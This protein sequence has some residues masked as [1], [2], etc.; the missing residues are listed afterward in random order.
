MTT[1]TL[2]FGAAGLLLLVIGGE[3]LVRGA[4]RVAGAVGL[5]PLIIGLTVVAFGTSA[6]ELAVSARASLA[7]RADLALGNV[8]GSNIF[9]VLFILGLSASILPL[10]VHVRLVR[11]EIPLMIASSVGLLLLSLDGRVGR[12][13]GLLLLAVLLAYT[14]WSVVEGRRAEREGTLES[15]GGPPGLPSA[16]DGRGGR[17]ALA[18]AGAV[19]GGLVLLVLGARWLVDAAM[20]SARALGVDELTIGVTVVAAGTSLP[21]VATSLVAAL[22]GQRDMAVGNVVGSNLFNVLGILGAAAALSPEGIAVAVAALRFDIPVLIAVSVACLP[23][24]FTGWSI[25]RWEGFLLLGYYGAYLA[26]VLLAQEAHAALP[27][28][29]RTMWMFVLPITALVL[30]VAAYRSART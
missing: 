3:L 27:A 26:Y 18:T 2:G 10:T 17:W 20:E 13:E 4:S 19:V 8:V 29:S 16:G 22:R 12:P 7:G 23:I 11:R 5:S 14:G 30:A 15:G 24:F 6:P 1:S 9:N 21:E 25:R 28:F